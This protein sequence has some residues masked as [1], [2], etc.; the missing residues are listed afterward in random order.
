MKSILFSL[1]A[2]ATVT[3]SLLALVIHQLSGLRTMIAYL[4]FAALCFLPAVISA[5]RLC[6]LEKKW[7]NP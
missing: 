5:R 6:R 7:G 1:I 2:F 3:V 4:V